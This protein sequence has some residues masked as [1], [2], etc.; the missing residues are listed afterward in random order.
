MSRLFNGVSSVSAGAVIYL[1][2]NL[3]LLVPAR[4]CN[5]TLDVISCFEMNTV[6]MSA[7]SGRQHYLLQLDSN[8]RPL[9][10]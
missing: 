5:L 9:S 8:S 2:F 10:E 1:A 4:I 6:E 7:E 3:H